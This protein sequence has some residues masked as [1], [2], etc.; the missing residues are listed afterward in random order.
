GREFVGRWSDSP[1]RGRVEFFWGLSEMAGHDYRKAAARFS[2][3]LSKW[4]SGPFADQASLLL[5]QCHHHNDSLDEAL[6]HYRQVLSRESSRFVADAM[7]GLSTLL[8]QRGKPAEAGAILDQLIENYPKSPLLRAARVQRGRTLFDVGEYARALALFELVASQEQ[9]ELSDDI[10]YW[11]AKCELRQERFAD[12][13]SRLTKAIAKHSDSELM[14]EMCYDRA[15]ALVRG[16]GDADAAIAALTD[17]RARFAE[18][19]MAPE[20]LQLLAMSEHRQKRYD[21]SGAHCREFLKRHGSHTLA[22]GIR[23]LSAENQFLAG[24]YAPAIRA[25]RDFLSNHPKD[26]QAARARFRL[27][28]ALYRT[29]EFAEAE[30]LLAGIV[31]DERGNEL[32]RSALLALGDIHFQRGEW[33]QAE[34]HLSDYLRAGLTSPSADSALLKLGLTRQRQGNYADAVEAYDRLIG[35]FGESSQLLQAR[36][37]RG[38][39]LAALKKPAEAAAEFEKVL[40]GG[41]SRFQTFALNHLGAIALQRKDYD[42]AADYYGRALDSDPPEQITAEAAF[43]RGQAHIAAG[44]FDKAAQDFKRVLDEF[45]THPRAAQARAQLAIALARQDRFADAVRVIGQI[46]KSGFK[47]IDAALAAS[48]QYEKAWCL[49]QLGKPSEA[50]D[51]Y[52]RLLADSSAKDLKV[53]VTLE[54]AEIQA[55]NKQFEKAAELL[56]PL[57]AQL[58]S[59]ADIPAKVREQGLYRLAVCEYELGKLPQAA[60]LFEEFLRDFEDSKLSASA[61]FFCG[62]AFFKTNRHSDAVRYL[63]RVVEKHASDPACGPALL[64]L[65]ES[66]AHLQRWAKSEKAFVDYLE[67]FGDSEHWFQAQFGIGW[68][69]ENQSRHDEAI[70]AYRDLIAKHKGPTAARAQFQIGE[71]LFAQKKYAQAATE[72]L[73]VDILYVYPQWSAAAL[74]EAGRC[75]EKMNQPAQARKQFKAVSEKYGETRWAS[76]AGQRLTQLSGGAPPG[77]NP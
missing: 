65:G 71:C 39:A 1:L 70:G 42:K 74:F 5:A 68:A 45:G 17:F 3:V 60:K 8:H 22:A 10:D 63:T 44:R 14:P 32:F 23:F 55:A 25:Y 41:D 53:H 75:F 46:E 56:R 58:S 77:R 34:R 49:K 6:E 38:Q 16:G 24:N 51:V 27:G 31:S 19:V 47:G 30:K 35:E 72:L 36:F 33:K 13:A 18:H 21:R 37:E 57:H 52:R 48:L 66:L 29:D 64:R 26:A 40:S 9:D 50:A 62:E 4:S 15:V 7:L 73:N 2:R 76:M 54:L 59:G 43:G 11:M 20:A 69:R 12:A 61:G 28:M 67:R